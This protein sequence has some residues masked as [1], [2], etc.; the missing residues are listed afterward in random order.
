M[1]NTV[2]PW[3]LNEKLDLNHLQEDGILYF[4]YTNHF[5]L[6]D[7]TLSTFVVEN[8]RVGWGLT[9]SLPCLWASR[10]HLD[11]HC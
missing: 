9:A 2:V 7:C 5:R 3:S 10:K 6:S 1:L 11:G 8:S 4:S